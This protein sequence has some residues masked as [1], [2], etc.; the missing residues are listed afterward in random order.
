MRT[1]SPPPPTRTED[2]VDVRHGV[3]VRDPYRWLEDG[4]AE[5]VRRWSEAQG[6]HTRAALDAIPFTA[7]IRERLRVLFSIGLVS[8]PAIRGDR[9]FHQR[10][11]GGQEQP[12]LYLRRG[13][14][15]EDRVLLD[16]ARLAEDRTSALDWYYPSEDG[17][18]LAYGVSEGGSEKSVLRVL[19]VD[20]GRELADVIPF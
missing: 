12:I 2:V 17:T 19:E 7:A 13:R 15:G 4:D 9:Y 10:R 16:P 8:A 6:R 18:L 11:T 20:T 14:D 3:F 5:E 1:S